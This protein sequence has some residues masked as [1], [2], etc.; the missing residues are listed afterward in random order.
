MFT[1]PALPDG[2]GIQDQIKRT[3]Y[4]KGDSLAAR[5]RLEQRYHVHVHEPET[6]GELLPP[7]KAGPEPGWGR[8]SIILP[9]VSAAVLLFAGA[10][11]YRNARGR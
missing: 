5:K 11:S 1:L 2:V 9:A 3:S 7:L 6:D 8:W 4:Y 10:I